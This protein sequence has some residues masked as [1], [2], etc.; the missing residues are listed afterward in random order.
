M[1][2]K[3][4]QYTLYSKTPSLLECCKIWVWFGDMTID[5]PEISQRLCRCTDNNCTYDNCLEQQLPTWQL[6]RRQLLRNSIFLI[7]CFI[8]P[9]TLFRINVTC[10]PIELIQ[11]PVNLSGHTASTSAAEPTVNKDFRHVSLSLKKLQQNLL[12]LNLKL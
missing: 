2:H 5:I 6:A 12:H 8:S 10:D 7:M 9:T 3:L 1:K 11:I 4:E